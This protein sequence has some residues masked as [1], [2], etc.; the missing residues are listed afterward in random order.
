MQD[1]PGLSDHK[2]R[3]QIAEV[4]YGF[5]NTSTLSSAIY[6]LLYNDQLKE[7]GI[8]VRTMNFVKYIVKNLQILP[9]G[10]ISMFFRILF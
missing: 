4:C 6:M 2:Q 3:V 7:N 9:Q 1:C 10:Q 5:Y 8:L